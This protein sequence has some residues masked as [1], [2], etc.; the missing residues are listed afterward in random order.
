MSMSGGSLY[1]AISIDTIGRN[2]GSGWGRRREPLTR[3]IVSQHS[4]ANEA[5]S[6]IATISNS[7]STHDATVAS[8]LSPP[9][10][11]VSTANQRYAI[12]DAAIVPKKTWPTGFH[13]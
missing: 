3:Q 5:D 4:N 10:N 9:S 6:V 13:T 8:T 11:V 1:A 12:P 2:A 7:R